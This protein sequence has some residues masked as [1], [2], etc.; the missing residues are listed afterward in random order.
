MNPHLQHLLSDLRIIAC[1][2]PRIVVRAVLRSARRVVW[3]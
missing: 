1:G 3:F 2:V